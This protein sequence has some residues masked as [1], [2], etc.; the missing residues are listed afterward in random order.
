MCFLQVSGGGRVNE[1]MMASVQFTN[2]F[3]FNLESV[4]L[5]MEGPGVMELKSRYYR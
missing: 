4:H 5:R 2:P 3:S 1:E